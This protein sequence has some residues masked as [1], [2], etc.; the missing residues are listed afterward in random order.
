MDLSIKGEN[1][2]RNEHAI[3][4]ALSLSRQPRALCCGGWH[5]PGLRELI[6]QRFK[7]PILIGTMTYQDRAVG[8]GEF[9]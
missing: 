8:G 9:T 1:H 5:A 2:S 4:L 3:I 6:Q 7:P